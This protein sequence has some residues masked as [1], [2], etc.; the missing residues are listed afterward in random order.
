MY[1]WIDF[2]NRT[3]GTVEAL[4]GD[5]EVWVEPPMTEVRS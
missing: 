2:N 3:S 1:Y 5:R 4:A